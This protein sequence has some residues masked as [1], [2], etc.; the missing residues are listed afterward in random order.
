MKEYLLC[1]IRIMRAT[2][3]VQVENPWPWDG[4]RGGTR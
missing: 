4:Y 3:I 1:D 2:E